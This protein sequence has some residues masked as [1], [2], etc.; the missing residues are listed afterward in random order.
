[1][2]AGGSGAGAV[3][4][5][6]AL[7]GSEGQHLAIEALH[8]LRKFV[9]AP[10]VRVAERMDGCLVLKSYNAAR[11]NQ[12]AGSPGA[13]LLCHVLRRFAVRRATPVV[14]VFA[15]EVLL[16]KTQ[17]L[18]MKDERVSIDLA[19]SSKACTARGLYNL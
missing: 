9:E 17:R 4:A 19:G 18:G 1:M 7:A 10:V 2:A 15:A 8:T 6:A 11:L 12:H 5:D 16:T 14:V 13:A 3:A